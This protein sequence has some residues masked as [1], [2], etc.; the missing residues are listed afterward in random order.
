MV[1]NYQQQ[2]LIG[3]SLEKGKIEEEI[4]IYLGSHGKYGGEKKNEVEINGRI[5]GGEEKT[6][7]NIQEI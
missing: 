1:D 4:R 3:A 7:G 6:E 5:D 2:L